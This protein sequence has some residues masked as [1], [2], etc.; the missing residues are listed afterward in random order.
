[1][2]MLEQWTNELKQKLN[3]ILSHTEKGE[4]CIVIREGKPIAEI[5]PVESSWPSWKRPIKK[6]ILPNVVNIQEYVEAERN[7]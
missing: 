1:M 4:R 2:Q 5:A 7:C 6:I 3:I